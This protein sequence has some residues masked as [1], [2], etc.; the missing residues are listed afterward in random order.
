MADNQ[1]GTSEAEAPQEPS[2]EE[3]IEAAE[4]EEGAMPTPEESQEEPTQE[5]QEEPSQSE[6][7]KDDRTAEQFNKLLES[8][9]ALKAEVEELKKSGQQP[10]QQESPWDGFSQPT[11]QQV[12]Q[13]VEDFTDADGNVDQ[14]GLNQ[15]L[16]GMAQ[17]VQQL[18]DYTRQTY[19]AQQKAENERQAR[20][21][22]E[23]YPQLSPDNDGYDATF[24]RMVLGVYAVEG[25][26]KTYL[27][28]AKEVAENY[29]GN[30]NEKKVREE[31]INDYKKTQAENQQG[32][33]EA[34]KGEVRV[35]QSDIN[36]IKERAQQGDERAIEL[37]I[38]MT[39][40]SE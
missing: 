25:G 6:E 39:E 10:Q 26:K 30:V 15:A 34:G 12:D 2:I 7:P 9:Q 37:L 20:E 8:N 29:K 17:K 19:E 33:V 21:A 23:Q 16:R 31:A 18:E 35:S 4:A 13:T 38:Q 40:A 27:E 14:D 11:Q 36:N 5:P 32:P 22:V 1:E 24:E 3:R 28:A